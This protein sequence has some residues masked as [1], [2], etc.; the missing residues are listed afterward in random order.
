M[1]SA[2]SFCLPEAWGN[3]GMRLKG[4]AHR[5]QTQ[6]SRKGMLL[7]GTGTMVTHGKTPIGAGT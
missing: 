7:F 1:G 5:I 2:G 3:N 4:E 6:T